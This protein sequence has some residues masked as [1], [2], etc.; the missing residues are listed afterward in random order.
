MAY[1]A[2]RAS[3]QAVQRL[4]RNGSLVAGCGEVGC[5]LE[6]RPSLAKLS[7]QAV[8]S[9]GQRPAVHQAGHGVVARFSLH[10]HIMERD[11]C[12]LGEG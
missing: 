10:S 8:L 3:R 1:R 5:A 11:G 2:R 7:W 12:F 9:A 6:V 4:A